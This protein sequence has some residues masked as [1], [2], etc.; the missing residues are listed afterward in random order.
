MGRNRWHTSALP[1]DEVVVVQMSDGTYWQG[2]IDGKENILYLDGGN[3]IETTSTPS[4]VVRWRH[5]YNYE[6]NGNS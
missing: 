1:V 5:P 3:R 2:W 6:L 4:N